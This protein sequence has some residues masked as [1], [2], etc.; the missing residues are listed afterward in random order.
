MRDKLSEQL[1]GFIGNDKGFVVF[2]A[3]PESGLTTTMDISLHE[4]DRLMRNFVSVEPDTMR[5]REIENV[6]VTTYQPAAGETPATVL[7]KLIRTYPDVIV[8][9][10]LSDPETANILCQQ[11]KENRLILTSIRAK[12]AP[13]A[14]LRVLMLKV[15][16]KEL[17]SAVTA[18]INQRLIRCLCDQCK[19]AYEPTPDVLQKL[20]IPEGRVSALYREPTAEEANKPCPA[21]RGLGYHG[22]VSIFE[23]LVVDEEV[24]EMLLNQPNLTKAKQVARKI[25]MRSLQEEGIVLVAKGIT[26]VAELTRVLNK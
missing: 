15:P 1:L 5:E 3:L 2:S 22:R 4:T 20:R 23:L 25:G 12:E 17:A 8:V 11:V 14:L 7:P 21:C 26:S 10:N 6:E 24:R 13:E 16:A 18:V 19:V 9:R